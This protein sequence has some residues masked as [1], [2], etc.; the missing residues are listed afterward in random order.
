FFHE[1]T[2]Y[3]DGNPQGWVVVRSAGE[4][5]SSAVSPERPIHREKAPT[6]RESAIAGRWPSLLDRFSTF[7]DE[8]GPVMRPLLEHAGQLFGS[9]A[10]AL[11]GCA[12][13]L[14]P[15][16]RMLADGGSTATLHRPGVPQCL[17]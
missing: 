2:L 1:L 16:N 17:L 13:L 9:L 12:V 11:L 14:A 7:R 3:T 5:V 10:L 4:V 8:E 6:R 15:E